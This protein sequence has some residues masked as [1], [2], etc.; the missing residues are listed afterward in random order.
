[1]VIRAAQPV[2]VDSGMAENRE[3]CLADVFSLV[4]PADIR[5]CSSATTT[6]TT[7]AISMP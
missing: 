1:L 2:V 4:E 7:P 6:S 3:Q 5:R